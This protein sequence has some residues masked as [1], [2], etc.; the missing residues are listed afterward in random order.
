[1]A[2][3]L[4]FAR[5][6]LRWNPFGEPLWEERLRLA[7]ATSRAPRTDRIV[8]FLGDAGH[9]KT[10]R[11]LATQRDHPH[12]RYHYI[13]DGSDRLPF[14]LEAGRAYLIDEAQRLRQRTLRRL[15]S[16]RYAVVVGSHADLSEF[17][18]VIVESET[19]TTTAKELEVILHHR[20]EW[21]RRGAGPVPEVS[22]RTLDRLITRFG[23]D[24]RAIEDHLYDVFQGLEDVSHV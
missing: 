20:I 17:A 19:V 11:L 22:P 13:P 4:A 6:N 15:L 24:V 9:G 2:Q 3:Q 18:S 14:P 21:A 1:M 10:T 5:L 7:V 8:Q 12:A 16:G 23:S